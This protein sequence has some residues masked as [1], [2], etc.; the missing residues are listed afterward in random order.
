MV[1][2]TNGMKAIFPS[3]SQI[4]DKEIFHLWD[5]PTPLNRWHIVLID[6]LANS[7]LQLGPM[8]MFGRAE[9]DRWNLPHHSLIHFFT[10]GKFLTFHRLHCNSSCLIAFGGRS[11]ISQLSLLLG[12][13]FLYIVFWLT[14][15]TRWIIFHS[16]KALFIKWPPDTSI[17][18][19][20]F[21]FSLFGWVLSLWH[22]ALDLFNGFPL[23][24]KLWV[25][26]FW[27]VS[28]A[29]DCSGHVLSRGWRKH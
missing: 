2:K 11:R 21:W 29:S 12:D 7:N 24:E 9:L 18:L 19:T 13:T 25:I 26:F 23:K 20:P 17:M 22:R 15:I 16:P 1:L 14:F 28:F 6:G 3:N 4:T 5:T 27:C 10:L 8:P